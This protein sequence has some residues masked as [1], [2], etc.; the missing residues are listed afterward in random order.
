[1]RSSLAA[2]LLAAL[3]VVG[4][5]C[6]TPAPEPPGPDGGY[7]PIEVGSAAVYMGVSHVTTGVGGAPGAGGSGGA[8]G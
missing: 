3:A 8:G 5:A 7:K 6:Q 2:W 1:M 4:A